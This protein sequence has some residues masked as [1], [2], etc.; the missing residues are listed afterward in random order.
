ML[1]P[2]FAG[3]ASRGGLRVSMTPTTRRTLSPRIWLLIAV[4]ALVAI[5]A[6]PGL[7]AGGLG[8]FVGGL[9]VS[10]LALIAGLLGGVLGG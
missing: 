3:G 4:A 6:L 2:I 7:M 5:L 9:W 1:R 8:R 10:T